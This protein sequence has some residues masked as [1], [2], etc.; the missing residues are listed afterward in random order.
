MRHGFLTFKSLR[1]RGNKNAFAWQCRGHE[2]TDGQQV[3]AYSVGGAVV[4]PIDAAVPHEL[5]TE[6]TNWNALLLRWNKTVGR[7]F[8]SPC[9]IGCSAAR[10][11]GRA[12]L[13]LSCSLG[14]NPGPPTGGPL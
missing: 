2:V 12:P 13:P 3:A 8:S 10:A 6:P 1:P 4:R 5:S 9:L 14:R 11:S 7:R